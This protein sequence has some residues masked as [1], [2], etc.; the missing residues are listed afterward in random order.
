MRRILRAPFLYAAVYSALIPGFAVLYQW[1]SEQFFHSTIEF[2]VGTANE[3]DSVRRRLNFTIIDEFL[4]NGDSS[5]LRR[6][7]GFGDLPRSTWQADVLGV[8]VADVGISNTPDPGRAKVTFDL[9]IPATTASTKR[10]AATVQHLGVS[11]PLQSPYAEES[12][13]QSVYVKPI[14]VEGRAPEFPFRAA[15]VFPRRHPTV[16]GGDAPTLMIPGDIQSDLEDLWRSRQG[17][18]AGIGG[19]FGR[20]LYLSAVTITTLGYGDIVPT[21]STARAL[22]ATESVLGIVVIGAFLGALQAR[23]GPAHRRDP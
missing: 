16:S 4:G 11:M 2:E 8:T 23:R 20:F 22:V 7:S 18:G 6:T 14:V 5:I 21:G 19:Q 10:D 13:Q 1:N 17:L 15:D 3:V 12:A 9:L